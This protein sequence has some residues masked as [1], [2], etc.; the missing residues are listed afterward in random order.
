MKGYGMVTIAA[1]LFAAAYAVLGNLL[2]GRWGLDASRSTPAEDRGKS[3]GPVLLAAR[4]AVCAAGAGLMA[5][6]VLA[7]EAGWT[8]ALLCILLGTVIAGSVQG[9]GTLFV[10]LRCGG[11]SPAAALREM[12][13]G[14]SFEALAGLLRLVTAALTAELTA[15]AL[16]SLLDAAGMT[17]ALS[18]P[19]HGVYLAAVCIPVLAASFVR[20]GGMRR[21]VC[22]LSGVLLFG[23]MA[24]LLLG[25]G[26]TRAPMTI[27][28]FAAPQDMSPADL[29]VL[30]LGCAFSFSYQSLLAA[31][32]SGRLARETHAVP[33]GMGS[34]LVGGLL[35]VLAMAAAGGAH[36][37]TLLRVQ[38][39]PA[40]VIAGGAASALAEGRAAQM[41]S[42]GMLAAMV[43]FGFASLDSTVILSLS[44]MRERN[45]RPLRRRRREKAAPILWR[46]CFLSL[47]GA[48]ACAGY[49]SLLALCAVVGTMTAAGICL[50]C[51]VWMRRVGRGYAGF[52][53]A[54]LISLAAG[55]AAAAALAAGLL[56]GGQSLPVT[57]VMLALAAAAVLSALWLLARGLRELCAA[58]E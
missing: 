13:C 42:I 6:P 2:A 24:V 30:L 43:L 57:A 49:R 39:D 11:V 9:F 44:A 53:A 27:P 17:A 37:A 22:A 41:I 28:P 12:G 10:C 21:A 51:A 20:E 52:A 18:A 3:T 54:A 47:T 58:D 15:H 29:A 50:L 55:V 45:A 38:A 14:R 26:A 34:V 32:A 1:V 7:M 35:A 25:A 5:A 56:S 40:M 4:H 46:I 8:P 33:V 48:L 19:G 16:C 36:G 31:D 23:F